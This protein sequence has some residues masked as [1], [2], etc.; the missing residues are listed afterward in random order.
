MHEGQIVNAG[1]PLLHL[2]D[3]RFASNVGETEADKLGL[4]AKV[5]RLTAEVENRDFIISPEIASRAPDVARGETEL[6]NSRREQ[7]H[8]EISGLEEQLVQ[9][10]RSCATLNRRRI[11]L[12]TA[13]G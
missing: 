6:Y 1:T 13:L 9:K 2:D 7:F 12:S 3:T 4:R 10:N 5:E 11:S 8:N